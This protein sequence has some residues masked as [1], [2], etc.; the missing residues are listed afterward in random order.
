ML[1]RL[2]IVVI[3]AS[4]LCSNAQASIFDI[5][6]FNARGIAMGGAQTAEA[7]DYTAAFYNPAAGVGPE[8][9]V[10][11][12][13]F[14]M[15][16]PF[17]SV[18]RSKPVCTGA[19]SICN[20]L[21]G[22][23]F[24][25]LDTA[26][27]QV[28]SGFTLGW[29]F[30]FGGQLKNRLTMALAV[31]MPTINIIRAEGLDPQMPQFYMYQNLPDQLVILSSL[32]YKP[33]DWLSVG[34]GAQV[35]A[36]VFGAATFDIDIVNGRFNEQNYKVELSP[37]AAAIAGLHITPTDALKIG[38]SYRQA[39]GL[40]FG[41][42]AKIYAS[43]AAKLLLQV[44]GSVLYTPHQFNAGVSY[45]FDDPALTVSVDLGVA[46]WSQ[47]PDPAPRV[48]VDFGGQLLDA[49]GLEDAIDIGTNTPPI[50]L[51]FQ[52]TLTPRVGV[53]WDA[54]DWLKLRGGYY[55]RPS[56]APRAN[57]AYNYLDNDLHAFSMG[58]AFIVSDPFGVHPK[59]ISL[60][61]T[62]Q[63]GWLPRRTVYK[64]DPQDP[65]GDLSHGGFTYLLSLTVNHAY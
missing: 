3:L 27:P 20:A 2:A 36:N 29:L 28:F 62:Q 63:L 16:A 57:G 43:N 46:L 38:L 9:I 50:S 23:R 54:A 14:M 10:W 17:L 6:G 51:S 30:P 59:P 44:G 56:P 39:I 42:P 7:N 5:Y 33:V 21:Y 19:Q 37:T 24:S 60:E 49:F 40:E 34:L 35:L 41:L 55:Y 25:P 18:T 12:G 26:L 47:A 32:A 13:G 52:D 15:T 64:D 4:G 65:I 1:K 61:L 8:N 31:Y 11:G 48:V 53:E 22:G 58:A 45:R